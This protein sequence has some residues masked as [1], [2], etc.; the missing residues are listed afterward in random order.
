MVLK[1]SNV[2]FSMIQFEFQQNSVQNY[3]FTIS[4]FSRVSLQ[5]LFYFFNCDLKIFKNCEISNLLPNVIIIFFVDS[6]TLEIEYTSFF[7]ISFTSDLIQLKNTTN[8]TLSN[9][10]FSFVLQKSG[11]FILSSDS[12]NAVLHNITIQK[13]RN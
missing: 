7:N 5:V 10:I 1:N 8:F 11:H 12:F 9:S 2:S 6:S 3:F 4:N 13:Y